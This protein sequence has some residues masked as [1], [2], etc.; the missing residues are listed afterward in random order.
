MFFSGIRLTILMKLSQ[1]VDSIMGNTL[2][3]VLRSKC[4]FQLFNYIIGKMKQDGI[5]Q[6]FQKRGLFYK[7]IYNCDNHKS[8]FEPLSY[9]NIISA[10]V[11]LLIGTICAVA[12]LVLCLSSQSGFSACALNVLVCTKNLYL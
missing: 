5:Y 12:Y 10:F 11:I 2:M 9:N 8:E 4:V 6:R 7:P 3:T 1:D